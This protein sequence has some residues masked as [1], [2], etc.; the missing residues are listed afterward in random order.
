LN[1]D[2]NP[3]IDLLSCIV[4]QQRMKIE[5]SMPDAHGLGVIQYR[6]LQCSGIERVRLFPP[7]SGFQLIRAQYRKA[8]GS[9]RERFSLSGLLWEMFC[10]N[11]GYTIG[12]KRDKSRA[13][14]GW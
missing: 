1:D 12:D 9:G 8:Y 13:N 11:T 2:K 10:N 7:K 3:L 5:K 6:C 14:Q 4:C